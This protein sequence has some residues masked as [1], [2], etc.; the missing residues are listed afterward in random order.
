MD[1]V[2]TE[3]AECVYLPSNLK[4]YYNSDL[5]TWVIDTNFAMGL[6]GNNNFNAC[7]SQ[8]REK[9]VEKTGCRTG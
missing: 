8:S 7:L 3:D 9:W 1:S 4:C 5:Q 6:G 2:L